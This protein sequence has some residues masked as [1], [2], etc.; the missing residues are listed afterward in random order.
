[1][2]SARTSSCNPEIFNL[3]KN[4]GLQLEM[5]NIGQT[6]WPVLGTISFLTDHYGRSIKKKLSPC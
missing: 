1:M 6:I 4:A 2:L 3:D 5:N